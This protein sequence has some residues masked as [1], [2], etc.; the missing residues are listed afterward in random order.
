M[1]TQIPLVLAALVATTTPALAQEFTGAKFSA[2][3]AFVAEDG[4]DLTGTSLN[5]SGGV[6]LSRQFALGGSLATYN[7]ATDD[8]D[9]DLFNATLRALYRVG[10]DATVGGFFAYDSI[11]DLDQET[12]GIETGYD[13]RSS[14][15][16]AYYGVIDVEDDS[17]QSIYGAEASFDVA[18]NFAVNAAFD[19]FRTSIGDADSTQTVT[20]LGGTFKLGNGATVYGNFGALNVESTNGIIEISGDANVAGIGVSFDVGSGRGT[21]MD[22]RSF[23]K[24]TLPF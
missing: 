13:T 16:E 20:T 18:P 23:I 22:N 17:E 7:I 3:Y 15:F 12:Y 1:N 14:H 9:V 21:V 6:T 8:S 11:E 5:A 24:A 4:A 2:N 10:P 19:T